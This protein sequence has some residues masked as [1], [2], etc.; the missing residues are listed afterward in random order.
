MVKILSKKIEE[1][2]SS[3]FE[4][5]VEHDKMLKHEIKDLNAKLAE[6]EVVNS[7]FVVR[8]EESRK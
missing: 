3:I 8:N 5:K 2:K 6:Q 7:D 1:L 4:T